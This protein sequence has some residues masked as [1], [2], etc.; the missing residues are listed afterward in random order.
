MC[1][2]AFVDIRER[3]MAHRQRVLKRQA[4][5]ATANFR[6]L[7]EDIT[8]TLKCERCGDVNDYEV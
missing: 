2:D 4:A 6:G 5:F 1:H 8:L 3:V 7:D